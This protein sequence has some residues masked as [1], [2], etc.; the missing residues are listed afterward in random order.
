MN[1][2]NTESHIRTIKLISQRYRLQFILSILISLFVA[3]M[4]FSATPYCSSI[5]Q[6]GL[7]THGTNGSINFGKNSRLIDSYNA[8]L[9]T[10]V[11]TID[12]TSVLKTCGKQDCTATGI[13]ID[14]LPVDKKESWPWENVYVYDNQTASIGSPEA[15]NFRNIELG[16]NATAVFVQSPT[17]YY[18]DKLTLGYKSIL[19]LS[20][21]DYW[22]NNFT[23]LAN[24]RIEIVG[25]GPVTFFVKGNFS[26]P[27]NF[28]INE[29]TKDPS[30]ISI[31]TYGY[32]DYAAGSRIWAFIRSQTSATL[33]HK[34]Q[35]YGGLLANSISLEGSSIVDFDAKAVDKMSFNYFCSGYVP[36]IDVTPPQ[37]DIVHPADISGP[38]TTLTGT[39]RDPGGIKR[40]ILRYGNTELPLALVNDQFSIKLPLEVG[41]NI[42]SVEAVDDAGNLTTRGVFLTREPIPGFKFLFDNY[43]PFQMADHLDI[44]GTLSIP[45]GHT[46][47]S[48]VVQTAS[49]ELSLPLV[50]NKFSITLPLVMGYNEYKFVA[51]DQYD[52]KTIEVL[53][54]GGL[55]G[56][57]LVDVQI[58]PD[59]GTN[60][61]REITGE[62]HSLWPAE[63]LVATFE[64]EPLELI[65]VT[66]IISRFKR[67]IVMT[68][69]RERF[70]IRVE[71]PNGE[72]TYG[73]FDSWYEQ[74]RT[75]VYL[76]NEYFTTTENATIFITGTLHLPVELIGAVTGIVVTSDQMPG[77]EI[78]VDWTAGAEQNST[79][80][81]EV[82]LAVGDNKLVVK[83]KKGNED[84]NPG[85]GWSQAELFVTRYE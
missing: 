65:P 39:I 63:S 81:V 50:D 77:I 11:V 23:A 16:T 29:N 66:N 8:R 79:F 9:N 13:P 52:N 20:A 69:Y 14:G 6:N 34:A 73:E 60:P 48:A 40:A 56:V 62:V 51:F 45:D 1:K 21:G 61:V 84:F 12:S 70:D 26:L 37:I 44:S 85:L 15:T 17:Y 10:P 25:E 4:S 78:P 33:K 46:I 54:A 27:L 59:F 83:A 42:F 55:E 68:D 5:F 18:I 80:S 3:P 49:G 7:Q 2:F 32:S 53:Q 75:V 71:A 35:I 41:E 76:D 67:T 57:E 82:P 31:Y 28:K 38:E 24:A 58:N 64:D 72:T 30:R 22:I 36:Y 19:R 74:D 43:E 47:K